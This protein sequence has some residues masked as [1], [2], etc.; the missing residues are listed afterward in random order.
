MYNVKKEYSPEQ[1]KSFIRRC[2]RKFDKRL[3]EVAEGILAK[4]DAS[5]KSVR[6]VALAGPSCSGKTTAAKKLSSVFNAAGK[7]AITVSIDDFYFNRQTLLSRSKDGTIDFDS[8]DTI[9]FEELRKC[10]EA[11]FS[12]VP[13]AVE[14]PVYDFVSGTRSGV[15]VIPEDP[16]RDDIYIFEGIQAFYPNVQSLFEGHC[17]SSVFIS[18]ESPLRVGGTVVDGN[19]I[20]FLRR[21]VRD[22]AKRDATAQYTFNLWNSVRDN[23]EKNIYPNVGIADFRIDSTMN[24]DISMLR[25]FAESI[26]AGVPSDDPFRPVSE[27]ILGSLGNAGTVSPEYLAKDSLYHEFV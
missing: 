20:R 17:T 14:I 26:L 3:E 11:I 7:N 2:D 19:Q 6:I 18:A 22:Y 27:R 1:A 10:V 13:R 24:Y 4:R 25:P 8:P 21:L 5:G 16:E 15:N 9:D 23:E 12:D